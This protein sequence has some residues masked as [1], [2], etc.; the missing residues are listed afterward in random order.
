MKQDIEI[1]GA[2]DWEAKSD[3]EG[4]IYNKPFEKTIIDENVFR[5]E[6]Q[7][8]VYFE[9]LVDIFITLNDERYSDLDTGDFT[10]GVWPVELEWS[11]SYGYRL[12]YTG[13]G[14]ERFEYC[15]Y[16]LTQL[17]EEFIPDTIARKSDLENLGG[18][19]S[20]STT[21]SYFKNIR[22][23]FDPIYLNIDDVDNTEGTSFDELGITEVQEEFLNFICMTRFSD[24]E[25]SDLYYIIEMDGDY[26][27]YVSLY[28]ISIEVRTYTEDDSEIVTTLYIDLNTRKI[29]KS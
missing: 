26:T 22:E 20:G 16:R 7:A 12:I 18:N 4:Y 27:G 29:T 25:F 15:I 19:A 2:S 17:D 5:R 9:E 21:S 28:G 13:S 11:K 8:S 24:A 14:E 10:N 23:N 1:G 6:G 3:D